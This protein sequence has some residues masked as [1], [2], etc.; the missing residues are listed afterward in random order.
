M[1]PP[2]VINIMFFGRKKVVLYIF[3]MKL[4]TKKKNKRRHIFISRGVK[5]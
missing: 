2:I 3:G 4:Q 5:Y 1:L